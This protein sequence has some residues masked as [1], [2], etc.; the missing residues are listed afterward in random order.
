MA[1]VRFETQTQGPDGTLHLP[2]VVCE[3]DDAWVKGNLEYNLLINGNP[4][5][6]VYSLPEDTEILPDDTPLTQKTLEEHISMQEFVNPDKAKVDILTQENKE[7][8]AMLKAFEK[9]LDA[10]EKKK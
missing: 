5:N 6:G 10:Q 7:L 8:K 1:K 2:D 4:V 3:V 9:R